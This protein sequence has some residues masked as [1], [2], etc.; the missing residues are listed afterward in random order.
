MITKLIVQKLNCKIIAVSKS[1]KKSLV[2]EGGLKKEEIKVIYNGISI[3]NKKKNQNKKT[4]KIN[5]LSVGIFG[6]VE[7]RKGHH[8]L[9]SSWK[10][11]QKKND[12]NTYRH[13]KRYSKRKRSY[14]F[15]SYNHDKLADL[16][17][18]C[19]A[20]HMDTRSMFFLFVH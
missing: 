9:I 13:C 14:F 17:S 1:L 3:Q 19:Q 2:I 6:R 11:V 7:H 18:R 4:I 8:L 5:Q 15:S 16:N 12:N 10:K 20:E